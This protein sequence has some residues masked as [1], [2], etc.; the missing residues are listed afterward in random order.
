MEKKFKFIDPGK[1]IDG[2]LELVLTKKVPADQVKKYVPGYEFEIR[3]TGDSTAMGTI[4]LRIGSALKLRYAGHIGYEV[5]EEFRGHRY[6]ARSCSMILP[7]ARRHGLGAVWL[8]VDP[9]NIPSR[10]TCELIGAKYI[11]AIRLPKDHE[12]YSQHSKFRR[13]YRL[14]LKK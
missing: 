7:L 1:L 13:R 3:R 9:K 11:K 2:D 5:K 6:A 8:T 4:R 10:K 14:D 12:M